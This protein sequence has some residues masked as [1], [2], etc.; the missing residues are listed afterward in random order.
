MR[1]AA[2]GSATACTA[3]VAPTPPAAPPSSWAHH[4]ADLTLRRRPASARVV[5]DRRP[6][7]QGFGA[8]WA[9][10]AIDLVGFGIVLPI[11]PLYAESD[12]FG[13]SP[14][15]I[16]LLVASFSLAQLLFAPL[17]GRMSDRVGRKPV[18]VVSLAGTAIGSL[19]TGLAPNLGVL[20]VGRVID[21]ISGA[22]ISVA[23][24]AVADVAAPEDRPRLLGL[25]GAAFGLGFVA[26]PAIG[27]LAALG[28]PQ[29]PFF[30]AAVLAAINAIVAARRL[31][32]TR[33]AAQS[34]PEPDR[35][36]RSDVVLPLVAVAFCS[37][38]AFSAFEATFA[39][40]GERRLG[41]RL[42]STGAVFA[43]I[44][45]CIAVANVA[46]V[47]P[48]VRRFGEAGALGVG[49]VAN[50]IGLLLLAPAQSWSTVAPALVLLTLGQGLVTPTLAS[51]V[52]GSAV[53]S[54]RGGA[55]G[56][57]QAASGLARVVGPAA[58]GLLFERVGIGAPYVAGA[59]LVLVA[60]GALAHFGRSR[61]EVVTVR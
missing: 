41:L 22:S 37:L 57:Q 1:Q 51:L 15:V 56:V 27:G 3:R 23:Q 58:G 2:G 26:G 35:P 50:A 36:W 24:A 14:G 45:V 30:L 11:L 42:A 19:L 17:W 59:G 6:L 32:E 48:T 54:R 25:L 53:A 39:L 9:S 40:M 8:I 52:A 20:F 38:A 61:A 46:V 43:A 44:G 18:L 33:P 28:G 4:G 13:A 12:R 29:L 47:Q 49:L 55:L 34:H 7:P 10:V 60:V 31:P 5:P 21:G 16:G